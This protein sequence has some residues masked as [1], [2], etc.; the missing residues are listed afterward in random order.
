MKWV[1]GTS[2]AAAILFQLVSPVQAQ[3]ALRSALSLQPEIE[4]SQLGT[5]NLQPDRPHLGPVQLALGLYGGLEFNDNVNSSE[6]NPQADLLL[7]GGLN[8][9]FFWPATTQSQINFS[10]SIGYVHY[11]K[12]T[13]Y[14]H[15]E[16]SPNSALSW[17]IGFD[18]GSITFYDQFSYSQQ[19]QTESALSGVATFPRLDNTIGT[20]VDWLPGRW[21]L[22]MGYSHNNSFSDESQ[23]AYLNSSSEYLFARGGWRFAENTQGGLEASSSFTRYELETQNNNYSVSLGPYLEWK[24]TQAI[25]ATLRG[26]PVFYVFE[27]PTAF[28]QGSQLNSYY[29][30]F[31]VSHKLNDF[32]SHGINIQ[33]SVHQGLNQGSSYNEVLTAAYSAS[34]ALTQR[35]SLGA[36]FTYAQGTQPFEVPV[37]IFPFGTFIFQQLENYTYYNPAINAS[38]RA[39]DKLTTTLAYNHFVRDSNIPQNHYT[40]NSISLA[41]SYSF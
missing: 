2:S 4:K 8:L 39:T 1:I 9:G 32:F 27:S 6:Q 24:V 37:N 35:V 34:F 33:R 3:D 18:D 25:H 26:G 5:V 16:I 40:A 21:A 14:N 15:L 10:S 20:R 22:A 19:V 13:Q 7:R 29:L 28:R 11:L 12:N 30:G 36:S 31:E 17:I 23:F 41:L 38:W